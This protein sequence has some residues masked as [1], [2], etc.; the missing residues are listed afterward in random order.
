MISVIIPYFNGE[1]LIDKAIE[2]LKKQTFKNFEIIIVDDFSRN[3]FYLKNL[4]AKKYNFLNIKIFRNKKNQ[5]TAYSLNRGIKNSSF[6]YISWLSH[7]D[8]YD[9][10][11]L[12]LD[13]MYLR[14]GHSVVYS[15]F[16]TVDKNYILKKKNKYKFKFFF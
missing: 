2:S 12:K 8:Y 13:L 15:N 4:V 11:K 16:Y 9:K 1:F 6:Q 5:G 7:D 3:K 14:Q 10:N